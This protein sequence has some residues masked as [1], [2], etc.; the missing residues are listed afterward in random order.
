MI[1]IAWDILK[2]VFAI[3]IYLAILSIANLPF[4]NVVIAGLGLIYLAIIS[5]GNVIIK[6]QIDSGISRTQQFHTLI[7]TIDRSADLES[8]VSSLNHL[9]ETARNLTPNYIVSILF[10]FIIWLISVIVIFRAVIA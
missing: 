5:Y 6:G 9:K 2:K 4:E 7:R 10:N 3:L 8:D 1:V